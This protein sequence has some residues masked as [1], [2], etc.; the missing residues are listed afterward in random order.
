MIALLISLY[1]L[2]FVIVILIEMFIEIDDDDFRL[3]LYGSSFFGVFYVVVVVLLIFGSVVAI[4]EIPNYLKKRNKKSK[5]NKPKKEKIEPLPVSKYD[6]WIKYI[7]SIPLD[8]WEKE[9]DVYVGTIGNVMIYIYMNKY[10]ID[11]T[12]K[13]ANIPNNETLEFD[14]EKEYLSTFLNNIDDEIERQYHLSKFQKILI[15]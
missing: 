12:I 3:T 7:L 13:F 4:S 5:E 15:D 9:G 8:Q 14:I 11:H 6:N 2:Q 1:L 10:N